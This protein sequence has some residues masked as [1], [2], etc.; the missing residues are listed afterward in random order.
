MISIVRNIQEKNLSQQSFR[1]FPNSVLFPNRSLNNIV[2]TTSK[3]A[4]K[5]KK[6]KKKERSVSESNM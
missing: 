6:K 2:N 1:E 3:Q 4:K 5:K